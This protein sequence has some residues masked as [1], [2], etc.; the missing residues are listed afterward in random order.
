MNC[1]ICNKKSRLWGHGDI[2]D[3]HSIAY[4]VCDHCDFLQTE[5][6]YWLKEAYSEAIATTDVGLVQR[7]LT[8]AGISR[9][10]IHSFFDSDGRFVDYGGGYGLFV[11]LMRDR[12][13]DFFRHD[14]KCENLFARCFEADPEGNDRFELVTAFEVFEHLAYPIPE[15]ERMLQFSDSILFSTLLISEPPKKPGDWWYFSPETGQHVSFYSLRSLRHLAE[16]FGLH[17]Y[18][19]HRQLHLLTA[20]KVSQPIFRCLAR[21]RIAKV[22]GRLHERKPLTEQ[23]YR[24]AVE[25]VGRE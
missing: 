9:A 2:L 20:R 7:N 24:R 21:S 3:K 12:G 1:R 23:D 14:P 19:D 8:A 17:L 16:H 10:M 18:T 6:P 4:F 15:I 22:Y 13:F 25:K 11:R 5:E